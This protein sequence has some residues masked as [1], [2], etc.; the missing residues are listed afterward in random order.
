MTNSDRGREGVKNHEN[1]ADVICTCPLT[2]LL[3]L[4]LFY[5][6]KKGKKNVSSKEVCGLVKGGACAEYS[7]VPIRALVRNVNPHS[8]GVIIL[9]AE[10][11]WMAPRHSRT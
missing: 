10:D 4:Q 2:M 1:L 11:E 5:I 7:K 6:L 3:P 8:H 9:L